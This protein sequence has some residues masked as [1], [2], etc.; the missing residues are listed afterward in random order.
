MCQ[1]YPDH[2][3]NKKE[4]HSHRDQKLA[5]GCTSNWLIDFTG[6]FLATGKDIVM[7]MAVFS[8]PGVVPCAEYVLI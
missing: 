5:N 6:D 4:F 8:V 1:E 7:F 2:K 3:N